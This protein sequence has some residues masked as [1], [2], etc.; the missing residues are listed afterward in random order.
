MHATVLQEQDLICAPQGR[1][2]VR[3]R[4]ARQVPPLEQPLP[5]QPLRLD[6]ERARQIVDD[7]QFRGPSEHPRRGDPLDLSARTA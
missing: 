3:D 5:E 1:V 7:Q 6:V 4:Q 2:A